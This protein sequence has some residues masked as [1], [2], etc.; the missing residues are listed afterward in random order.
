MSIAGIVLGVLVVW[1]V[2]HLLQAEDGP[3]QLVAR[4][5]RAAGPGFWG[6]LIDCFYCLSLWLSLPAALLIGSGW[7]EWLL[8]WL[9][10]SG[11]AMLL[12]RAT[13][14]AALFLEDPREEYDVMLRQGEAAP[15]PGDGDYVS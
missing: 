10:L 3:W 1:R 9:G 14:R 13:G 15:R 6:Q 4:L 8:L 12:E 5:R 7:R 11:G 2:T